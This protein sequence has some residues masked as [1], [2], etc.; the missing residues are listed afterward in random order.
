MHPCAMRVFSFF[1]NGIETDADPCTV[2]LVD[3]QHS[4]QWKVIHSTH[5]KQQ[6][7]NICDSVLLKSDWEPWSRKT[8]GRKLGEGPPHTKWS[9]W[10]LAVL[11]RNIRY[12][13]STNLICMDP[14][15]TWNF[16]ELSP[17]QMTW[18]ATWEPHKL[19]IGTTTCVKQTI[20]RR[21][22]LWSMWQGLHI[23]AYYPRN[24]QVSRQRVFSDENT[25]WI[26]HLFLLSTFRDMRATTLPRSDSMWCFVLE[27]NNWKEISRCTT[28]FQPSSQIFIF[29][30]TIPS[31]STE[32][33]I[34]G[35]TPM[36]IWSTAAM[37]SC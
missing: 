34:R 12:T 19:C 6:A 1:S 18:T 17:A 33:D 28:S 37:Y 20:P 15:Q 9:H 36:P 10:K 26:N 3:G 11:Q 5:A 7:I 21:F 4:S 22:L 13:L 30:A 27:S 35:P 16:G 32:M 24:T 8:L 23:T 14:P 25:L 29:E 2:C 31:K